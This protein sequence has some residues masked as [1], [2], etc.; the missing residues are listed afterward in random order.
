MPKPKKRPKKG[1]TPIR[2]SRVRQKAE[3]P[4]RILGVRNRG[5]T[6]WVASLKCLRCRKLGRQQESPTEC[7]HMPDS[8][9][10]G[11][12]GNCWPLCAECH[13]TAPD[14]WHRN[15]RKFVESCGINVPGESGKLNLTEKDTIR[16]IAESYTQNYRI[17]VL[18]DEIG[19]ERY[20]R[21]RSVG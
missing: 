14:S 11:D 19:R 9:R 10:F 6:Q 2:R 5:L 17:V 4:R 1:R 16:K 3:K 13:R 7:S 8:R 18:V 15:H 21:E 12:E 20:D